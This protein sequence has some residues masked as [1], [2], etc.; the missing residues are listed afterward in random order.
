MVINPDLPNLGLSSLHNLRNSH[1]AV[2]PKGKDS[3]LNRFHDYFSG[4]ERSYLKVN[5]TGSTRVAPEHIGFY[6]NWDDNS[7]TSLKRNIANLD[8]LMPE[9]IHLEDA[10][11][12]IALD[13]PDKQKQTLHYVRAT[14]ENLPVIPL[15]NNFDSKT[16]SWDGA[17][18]GALLADPR[19][20]DTLIRN[21]FRLVRDNHFRGVNIDFESIPAGS[22]QNLLTFMEEIGAKFHSAGLE[23]S[24]SVPLDDPA[25]DYSRLAEVNDYLILMAY[26]ENSSVDDVGPIASQDWF[27]K[28]LRNRVGGVPANKLVVAIGNYGYDWT[29]E[30]PPAE[31]IAFQDAIRIAKES[32]AQIKLDPASLNETFD[33]YDEKQRLHHVWFLDAITA[34][35]QVKAAQQYGVRGFA[36]WRMGSEDP[37]LWEV[38][39]KEERLERSTV[40]EL[41]KIHYGYDIDYEGSGEVLKVTDTPKDGEREINYD[42]K[43]GLIVDQTLRSYP[44]SYVINRWGAN[45]RHKIALTF[46]DGPDSDYTPQILDILKERNVKATFFIIGMNA[47]LN[48]DLLRRIYD[49]G[50]DIG[51]HTFTHPNI[52]ITSQEQLKLELNVTERLL[53]TQLGRRTLIFRPPYAEDVEPETP[54]QVAPLEFTGSMGYYTIG[55]QIDPLDWKNPGVEKIV[56]ETIRQVEA[57]LGNVVLLHDS[58]GDRSQTLAALPQ[59]I[60]A[61]QQRGFQL[62]T[63]SELIGLPR[64]KVMPVATK[65]DR[66]LLDFDWLGFFLFQQGNSLARF[67]FL[68]GIGLSLIRLLFIAS[69]ALYEWY[70]RRGR[71][72]PDD[73]YPTV[74]VIVPAYNEEKVIVKTINSILRSHYP[75]FHILVIDDGSN[76]GTHQRLLETFGEEPRVR[77]LCQSNGGKSEALNHGIS[78]TDAEIIV[79]LDADTVLRPDAIGKLVRHFHNPNMG[80]VA[81]NAKVGN[82]IN[83][84]TYWQALEYITSQNLERR[85]F[86]FLNCI[87]V[88]PGAIGAWRRELLL[89]TGGF[90]SDTLAEDTDLTLTVLEMG[91]K[92][93]YEVAAIALTEAPD[94][95][96]AFLKQRFRWM[97]GTL[98]S[99]WKHRYAL[100]R[101]RYGTVGFFALPN[102]LIFQILFPLVSPLLDAFMLFSVLWFSWLKG[103]HPDV[104]ISGD[105]QRI[106]VYYLLFLALD[107]TVAFIAFA[108]EPKE[109]WKLVIWLLPQRFF[110]RQLMYYVA[111]KSV[112]TAIHGQIIGWGKLERKS[113]VTDAGTSF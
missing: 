107:L 44:S 7:F 62:V 83:I 10:S 89:K 98:Q 67:L 68:I 110:Y 6:V 64:D 100:F 60:D 8:K 22:Q 112:L 2:A 32:E 23:I 19:A 46:D 71:R 96:R 75:N 70:G 11:G 3:L 53:E 59:L 76:D 78:K 87:S 50:H 81:G 36:L 48:T 86:G 56:A 69:L 91:Y 109:D 113:T 29:G 39:E 43:L 9:W 26:D 47:S 63:V 88:V 102:L 65:K 94:T 103:Q 30:H 58:G 77:I 111:I 15:I 5:E 51:S 24:Q 74:A 40:K 105:G 84:L 79:T 82:R 28:H 66:F 25:F 90:V 54:E 80:A 42:D 4:R 27:V 17:K 73:Y 38:W 49:E 18:V 1:L 52:A 99:V 92:I 45:D 12:A 108:L 61:L 41:T 85:A 106:M 31:E 57:G 20:R 37:S 13:D 95:V 35:N 72:Y 33:Y 101:A 93:D 97:F 104:A 21:L 14:R 34:F 55:M 16:M